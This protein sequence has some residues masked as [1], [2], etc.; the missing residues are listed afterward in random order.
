MAKQI[1]ID[2]QESESELIT[3]LHR[4]QGNLLQYQRVKALLLIKQGK[5]VYSYQLAKKLKRERK[6]IYNWLKLYQQSGIEAYLKIKS[7]GWRREQIPTTVKQGIGEKLCDPSS[8]ITSY[9]ELLDWV[10]THYNL[11][12]NYKTLYSHCRTHHKSVLKV[13]RKSHYKKDAMAVEAFKKTT[14]E[15]SGDKKQSKEGLL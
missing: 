9:V 8:V 10:A 6:T 12:V 15:S 11:L 14:R 5:V 2:I 13:A 7:R 3:L 4:H 1:E